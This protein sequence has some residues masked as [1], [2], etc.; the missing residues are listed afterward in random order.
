MLITQLSE[1]RNADLGD[2]I[3][4]TASLQEITLV[5]AM[6]VEI[7][8]PP[9]PDQLGAKKKDAGKKATRAA[10]EAETEKGKSLLL[11]ISQSLFNWN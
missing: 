2:A 10:S 5:G 3:E 9:V 11:Q 7:A 1:P 6:L 8:P 4:F